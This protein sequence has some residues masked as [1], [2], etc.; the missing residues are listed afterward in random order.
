MKIHFFV[1]LALFLVNAFPLTIQAQ[2]SPNPIENHNE[3]CGFQT[4]QNQL[5]ENNPELRPS[6][7]PA[8]KK[9]EKWTQNYTSHNNR[10]QVVLTI[11]TVVHVVHDNG[12]ENLTD[13]EI[14]DAIALLNEDFSGTNEEVPNEIHPSFLSSV[15]D[16][17]VRFELARFDPNG[18]PTTGITRQISEY[19][20]AGDDPDMKLAYRWPREKYMNIWLVNKPFAGNSSSGFAY[21][22]WSVDDPV[23]EHYDDI[24]IAYWAFG[25]HDETYSG[26]EHVLSHEVGHWANLKHTWGDQTNVETSEACGDDDD[27]SDTPNTTGHSFFGDC[28]LETYSC[29]TLDNNNNFMDYTGTCT[30]MFTWGQRDRMRAAIESNVSQRNNL[31]SATNLNETLGDPNAPRLVYEKLSVQ[32]AIS[33]DGTV[34]ASINITLENAL[35]SQSSGDFTENTHYTVSGLPNGITATISLNS[36]ISAVLHLNG[37][38]TNHDETDDAAIS[39]Y[40]QDAAFN[41]TLATNIPGSTNDL[42]SINFIAPYT[43]IFVDLEDP[44]AQIGGQ[45]WEYFDVNYGNADFGTWLYNGDHLKLETYDKG[46]ICEPGTRNITPLPCGFSIGPDDTFTPPEIYP[47]QLDISNPTYTAWNGVSAYI[48]FSFRRAGYDHYGWLK[49]TVSAD[50]TIFTVTEA[51]YHTGPKYPILTGTGCAPAV[52]YEPPYIAEAIAND[53]SFDG[54]LYILAENVS[55]SQSSGIFTENTHYSLSGLP[56]GLSATVEVENE[57]L[58][59][60]HVQGNTSNHDDV[61]DTHFNFSLLDAAFQSELAANVSNATNTSLLLDYRDPYEVVCVDLDDPFAQ[62]G[63]QTWEWFTLDFGNG[64]FGTWLYND[65]NYKLETYNKGAMCYTD[66][67]N[68]RPL[69]Y[70]DVIGP[71]ETFTPPGSYPDQLDVANPS[72]TNW[73]GQTAYIGFELTYNGNK[74]YGWFLAAVNSNG[75]SFTILEGAYNLAPN[76]MVFAGFCG[77]SSPLGVSFDKTDVSCNG[78]SDGSITAN[79][80]GGTAPFTYNWQHGG[81]QATTSNLAIG[82]YR[83]TVQDVLN[84]WAIGEVTIEE[85]AALLITAAPTNASASGTSDGA[86]DV[87]V[88]GG[89]PPYTFLWSNGAD[90]EDLNNIPSG[91]YQVY[92]WDANGC[93]E[94]ASVLVVAGS[95][96]DGYC[97]AWT[98]YDYNH[99]SNVNIAGIDHGSGWNNGYVDF[100]NIAGLMELGNSYPLTINCES[101]HWPDIAIAAWVD[102]NMD[103]DFEDANEEVYR[104]RDEGPFTTTISV[105]NDI[106]NGVT[107]MR[108]RLGYG[109]DMQPCGYDNYQGEVE[110]YSINLSNGAALDLELLDF[111]VKKQEETAFL[112]WKT[113][114][115]SSMSHFILEKSV[116]G[117]DFEHLHTTSVQNKEAAVYHFVD[118]KPFSGLNYYRLKAVGW[119]NKTTISKIVAIDFGQKTD[120]SLYPN[121]FGNEKVWLVFDEQ[122]EETVEVEVINQMGQIVK[123]QIV[124]KNTKSVTLEVDDLERGIYFLKMNG[125]LGISRLVKIYE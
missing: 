70:G 66:T 80:I 40:F 78:D 16:I 56:A 14:I 43:V 44:H 69:G 51:A 111:S 85:P 122:R 99:I 21:Y 30:G 47:G 86:I 61:N 106:E 68:I 34:N 4:I 19:T 103:G 3:K 88:V 102:W 110:D 81:N 50:G 83:V 24:V 26:Y 113:L 79:P 90:T 104:V 6:I 20:Y 84:N 119:D 74:H 82:E 62:Y 109:D 15:A 60:I 18:I 48:G 45:E 59:A 120:F 23:Y 123:T 114:N 37:T 25:R 13:A 28:T 76:T 36:S 73:F 118:E 33:N 1:L 101:E 49:A 116:N 121:P 27:V 35:F 91:S 72:Y 53:G 124:G 2:K 75:T 107:R 52:N 31:W 100:T 112:Q 9:L 38:T 95:A 8:H 17:E 10:N 11:P 67:R 89:T 41:G 71:T 64:D 105:P 87:T 93:N 63:V 58:L 117:K 98:E 5:Y 92:V 94:Q 7:N 108:I 39:I 57:A 65:V 46:A 42:L 12:P 77:G 96:P 125:V 115:E 97:E 22:P 55:F 29:G 54:R 32:E